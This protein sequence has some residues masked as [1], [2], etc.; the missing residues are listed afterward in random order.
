VGFLPAEFA[1]VYPMQASESRSVTAGSRREGGIAVAGQRDGGPLLGDGSNCPDAYQL[2]ALLAPDLSDTRQEHVQ[3]IGNPVTDPP[4]RQ[5]VSELEWTRRILGIDTQEGMRVSDRRISHLRGPKGLASKERGHR[6]HLKT[7]LALQL[8]F[9]FK[10]RALSDRLV[11][12]TP[13]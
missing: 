1:T 7:D 11:S 8:S 6:G 2:A 5:S 9:C 12:S 4:E 13:E 3:A 10:V